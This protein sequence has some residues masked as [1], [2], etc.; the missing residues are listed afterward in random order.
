MGDVLEISE[1]PDQFIYQH[2]AY[3]QRFAPTKRPDSLS[4]KSSGI[5]SALQHRKDII[6]PSKTAVATTN[7]L[8]RGVRLWPT[9]MEVTSKHLITITLLFPTLLFLLHTNHPH[10]PRPPHPRHPWLHHIWHQHRPDTQRSHNLSTRLHLL[11]ASLPPIRHQ[12]THPLIRLRD[13]I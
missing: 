10:T 12:S 1:G 2:V 8:Q 5:R 6:K 3:P 9:K 11:M 7:A 13:L 4:L